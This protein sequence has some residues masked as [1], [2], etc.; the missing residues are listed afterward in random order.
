[1]IE[2]KELAKF[3]SNKTIIYP[4]RLSGLKA[5]NP[6]TPFTKSIWI[7][8][9]ILTAKTIAGNH[10][11][12]KLP[13]PKITHN[14]LVSDISFYKARAFDAMLDFRAGDKT[15]AKDA[16]TK[17]CLFGCRSLLLLKKEPFPLLF[18][19]IVKRSHRYLKDEFKNLPLYALQVREGKRELDIEHSYQ[20]IAMFTQDIEEVALGE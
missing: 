8:E 4:F 2:R 13:L 14:D 1:M 6:D 12:E 20:A 15:S 5:H 9:I 11:I 7:T 3:I 17:A 16:F 10:I 18:D 19:E